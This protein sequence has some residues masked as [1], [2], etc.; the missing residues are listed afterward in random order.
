ML[1]PN[2]GYV[3]TLAI[4]P[5]EMNGLE[6]L[7][8][9]T[10]DRM[11]P[12]FLLAPWTTANSLAKAVERAEKAYPERPYFLDIDRDYA[13]SDPKTD[14]PH[15]LMELKRSDGCY[16]K[17]WEFVEPFENAF[18]CLQLEEQTP[19]CIRSQIERVQELGRQFCL[20]VVLGRPHT[21]LAEVVRVLNEIGTADY[22]VV[23]EGGWTEDPLTLA[24]RFLG[25]IGG[26]LGDLDANIP[27]VVSSTSMPIEFQD[28]EGCVR[29]PFSNHELIAQIAQ[30]TNRA[31]IVYGDWGST[32]PRERAGHRSRPYD[33]IDYPLSNAWLIARN[34]AEE[35]SFRDAAEEIVRRSGEWDDDLNIWGA[36]MI[37]QTLANPAFGINTPQKN[38]A[39]RVN[40][41]LHRQAFYGEDTH[42][43]DFDDDWPDEL[44]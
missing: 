18:P 43:F 17:W 38:V 4:R 2:I 23:L 13:N 19:D 6:E 34:R 44:N 29:V 9:L 21:N 25:L 12:L 32:R 22:T 24:A 1:P 41:H 31:R 7:P 5:S 15:E 42:G 28:Y 39:A 26:G 40:I 37:L 30:N 16:A 35:W 33:R 20:R 11:F 3:P 8:G 27:I 14:A 36:N 10:K